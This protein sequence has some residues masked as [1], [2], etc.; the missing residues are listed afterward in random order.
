MFIK[1]TILG[2]LQGVTEFLPISSTGHLIILESYFRFLPKE[3]ELSFDI[4]LHL[5]TLLALTFYFRKKLAKI[6]LGL[7]NTVKT[8]KIKTREEQLAWIILISTI[9]AALF[10]FLLEDYIALNF[11]SPKVVAFSLVSFSFAFLAAE[12][13]GKKKKTIKRLNIKQ[14]FLIGLAQAIALIPGVSRSGITISSGMLLN[15]KR[16]ESARFAFLLSIPIIFAAGLKNTLEMTFS[17]D[18]ATNFYPFLI[19]VFF[20]FIS[21]LLV[22][23]YF[24]K[25]LSQKSLYPF[26]F[27]RIIVG[28]IILLYV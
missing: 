28:L 8:G 19:G 13:I 12:V 24:L 7:F 15:F 16:E 27:Y 17:F 11:R 22:I 6:L 20:A 18:L 23:K 9:P 1:A 10:G 25:Y 21:S 14:G 3:V 2:V 5:G 26:V 4:A